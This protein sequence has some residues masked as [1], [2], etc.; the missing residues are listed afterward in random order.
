MSIAN[1]QGNVLSKNEINKCKLILQSPL[2][3]VQDGDASKKVNLLGNDSSDIMYPLADDGGL[4]FEN[5]PAGISLVNTSSYTAYELMHSNYE[6]NAY[7]KSAISDFQIQSVKLTAE[8]R[9]K[10]DYMLAALLFL[11]TFTKMNYGQNDPDA[12]MPPRLMNF[13]A[14][15]EHMFNNVPVAIRTYTINLPDT[16]DY[17]QTSFNTQVPLILEMNITLTFMPTPSKIK[18]EFSLSKFA[19]GSLIKKGYL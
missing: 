7:Q 8:T 18:R 2:G 13:S 17:V 9:E 14:Y 11:R 16:V 5:T 15:G 10:A 12:G 19:N 1:K 3:T 6:L 4:V